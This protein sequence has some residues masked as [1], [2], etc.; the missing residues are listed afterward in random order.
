MLDLHP[1]RYELMLT[2]WE[3]EAEKRPTFTEIISQYHSGLLPGTSKGSEGQGYALLGPEE[4][5]V[6][7]QSQQRLFNDTSVMDITIIHQLCMTPPAG[8]TFDVTFLS[9]SSRK[10]SQ[11]AAAMPDMEYYMKMNS[12]SIGA[13]VFVNLA[14]HEY[15]NVSED[16]EERGH[17][18]TDVDHVTHS[19]THSHSNESHKL[20][21]GC[22]YVHMKAAEPAVPTSK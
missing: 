10:G 13:N 5:K 1:Q 15:D 19:T 8:S 21:A 11:S 17:V 7:V 9:P 14:T 18:T 2:C 20:N 3:E 6:P 16:Q 4:K 12:P 22:D